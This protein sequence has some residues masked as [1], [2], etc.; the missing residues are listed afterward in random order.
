LTRRCVLALAG[1]GL[2]HAAARPRWELGANTAIDGYSLADAIRTV[3][4]LGFTAIEVHPMGEPQASPGKFPGFQFDR[5]SQAQRADL[6]ESLRGFRHVTTHLPYTGLNYMTRTADARVVETAMEATHYLGAKLAVL[7]PQPLDEV[8][9]ESAWPRYLER[10]QTWGDRARRLGFRLALETGYPRSVRGYV[11]LVREIDHRDVGATI[12]VGHQARYAELAA[13]VPPEERS[14]EA[15]IRAYNDTTISIVEQLGSK[16][17]H[18]HVHDIDPATWQEHQPLI[19]GFVDYRRLFATLR[20][21]GY[22]G[23]LM[24]EIGGPAAGLGSS[25]RDSRRKLLDLMREGAPTASR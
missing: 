16:V 23:V 10:F 13:R 25:L 19:H 3:R 15:G 22:K 4:E 5:L 21:I 2:V 18:F 8:E 7:H 14:T 24:F 12:D 17:F 6:R 1:A 11:R 9:L 20:Q